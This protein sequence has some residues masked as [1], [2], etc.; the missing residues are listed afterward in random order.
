MTEIT[1]Q[2]DP[3]VG[4]IAAASDWW[5]GAV[6]YQV[7][8]RSLFDASGDG[9]GDLPG[10]IEKLDYIASLGVDA[11]WISPF[12]KSPM[13]DF[14]YDVSDFRAVDPLFGSLE[15]FDGLIAKAHSLGLRVVIDLVMSH[16]SDQHQW[17]RD[18]Q[19]RRNGRDDWYVWADAKADGSVPNNW[20]S[21]FG[22]SAWEWHDGR[23]QYYLHNFLASQPDLNF[24]QIA[25]QD[26]ML[27][28]L[29]FWLKRGVDGFRLDAVNYCFH[30]AQLRNNPTKPESERKGRGFSPDNPYA[31]QY[32]RYDN[33]QPENLAFMER[34][35]GLLNR[36][37]G[38]VSLGEI[39]SDDSNA[40]IAEYTNGDRRLHMGYSF[41]LLA[42]EC[43]PAY[44][45]Q[46]VEDLEDRLAEGW[47]C[48]AISNHDV[49]RV[50]T[51]W[52]S[53]DASAARTKLLTTMVCSLRGT[54]CTY[55]GEELGLS[56]AEIRQDQVQDP[57]GIAFW[58]N[59]KGRDGCRTPMPWVANGPGA[60]F[61][62]AEPWLP[63]PDQHRADAVE[64]QETDAQSVL[65]HYRRF[66]RWRGSQ[67]ALRWGSIEF[68]DTP[69]AVL[70]F[71]R[72]F[73][74]Q[75]M[76][77]L[78]N[79]ST[80][81][82]SINLPTGWQLTEIEVGGE[83]VGRYA[84]AVALAPFQAWFGE[85]EIHAEAHAQQQSASLVG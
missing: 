28:E 18:S 76:L 5:R 74:D 68:I 82:C 79:F 39:N 12:F 56:E 57:Y 77:I 26:Q 51:R 27:A 43:S 54:V 23:Q 50:A 14:G 45:R 47:P 59:F 48:W 71:V 75:R 36:Y 61:S 80:S 31:W 55:Q 3:S 11:L 16:T 40:T 60:G 62:E 17:F 15:D 2:A 44:I 67:P 81:D 9:V 42:D 7:Y 58:P 24:H 46:T 37:P 34:I 83:T 4:Q 20:L 30:D 21:V 41:E 49:V 72:E 35:R 65:N 73:Q 53:D 22:G 70:G 69:A 84:E 6:I 38:S 1:T 78:M 19:T 10:I 64:I 52:G 32:H 33:T 8:P 25:V 85:L 13:K 63:I 29:E 66:L